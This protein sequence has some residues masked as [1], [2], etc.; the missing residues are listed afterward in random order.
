MYLQWKKT[1][2]EDFIVGSYR[3]LFDM[4]KTRQR[5]KFSKLQEKIVGFRTEEQN[6]D[7]ESI[8]KGG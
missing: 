7:S 5:D 4:T 1:Q 8:R 6:D 3:K 2:L